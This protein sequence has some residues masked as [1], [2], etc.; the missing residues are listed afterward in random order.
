M[1]LKRKLSILLLLLWLPGIALFGTEAQ[2]TSVTGTAEYRVGSAGSWQEIEPGMELPVSAQVVTSFR[3]SLRLEINRTEVTLGPLSRV[4]ISDLG[5]ENSALD[6]GFELP[7]GRLR[8]NVKTDTGESADFRVRSPISTAAVRGTTFAFD[9]FEL[10]VESGDVSFRN[11]TG[12]SH[13]VR[14]GL[15]SRTYAYEPIVSVEETLLEEI[16]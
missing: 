11:N 1:S 3:S 6:A 12:Q 8:A 4:T 15:S 5:E 16:E 9:G 10:A 2:V 7:Y 14:A 13:S